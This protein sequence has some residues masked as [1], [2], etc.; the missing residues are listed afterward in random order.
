M[1]PKILLTHTATDVDSRSRMV[2]E[3]RI[4]KWFGVKAPLAAIGEKAAAR[5]GEQTPATWIASV[6][7]DHF[8]VHVAIGSARHV[9]CD[10]DLGAIA[11][12]ARRAD[13]VERLRSEGVLDSAEVARF[14]KRHPD[15]GK[16]AALR[17]ALA[18]KLKAFEAMKAELV[19]LRA[20]LAAAG[21]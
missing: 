3:A 20:A 17:K 4:A 15:A 18:E 2:I 12:P 1:K 19:A 21:G 9:V 11:D 13:I 14:T 8:L 6:L 16:L 10:V 7:N 5:V